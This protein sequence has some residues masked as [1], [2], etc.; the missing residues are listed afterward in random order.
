MQQLSDNFVKGNV[1]FSLPSP[2]AYISLISLPCD[3]VGT[4]IQN[5]VSVA[6]KAVSVLLYCMSKKS[7]DPYS[8]LQH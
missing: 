2:K 7:W 6:V 8:N 1:K 3:L 4:I 5:N